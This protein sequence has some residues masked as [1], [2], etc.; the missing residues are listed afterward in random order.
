MSPVY[1]VTSLPGLYPLFF[2]SLD[3][4]VPSSPLPRRER[5][6]V[7]VSFPLTLT[8]S[9]KGREDCSSPSTAESLLSSP[10]TGED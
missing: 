7:R 8:L 4:R 9:R 6:K 10:L 2:L 1:F 5:I 3:G